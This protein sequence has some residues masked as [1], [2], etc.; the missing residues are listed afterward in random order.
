MTKQT[1]LMISLAPALLLG[2]CSGAENSDAAKTEE[3]TEISETKPIK[4]V[5]VEPIDE[6]STID[7]GLAVGEKAPMDAA[8]ATVEGKTT[9]AE[10]VAGRP[11]VL[12][13][14]RSVEWC[15]FCQTQLKAINGIVADLSE[16][17]YQIHG[18]S[19][20]DPGPQDRFA[21]NQMLQY[22]MLSDKPSAVI[23]AFGIRDPQYTEGRAM[24]VPYAAVF[25][26]GSDGTILAK[27]VSNDYKKRPTN[28]QILAI[29][30]SI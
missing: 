17:G 6:S 13:F 22:K 28:A 12:V 19:Y 2:A 23:D 7:A 4:S 1:I 20:D 18:V 14:T 3:S 10:I 16:R 27:S 8:F 26:V 11:A 15:P 21:M 30:D 9:L 25:V 24:G 29:V 5:I